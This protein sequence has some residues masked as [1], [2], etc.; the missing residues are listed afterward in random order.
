MSEKPTVFFS[1]A[2][3][4][5]AQLIRLKD[6]F[7]QKTGGAIDV[8]L[9]SDGQ[10][11]PLGVNWVHSLQDALNRA[12]LMFVFISPNS[13]HS[14]WL[15]FE[16][17]FSYAKNIRVVPLGFRGVDLSSLPPPLSLLQGFNITSAAGLDNLI[18]VPNEVFSHNHTQKFSY[19]EFCET[20]GDMAFK[21]QL[22]VGAYGTLIDE[23]KIDTPKA[24]LNLA[25]D[26]ALER[27]VEMLKA[28]GVEHQL[29]G[30]QLA[31]PG[32]IIE[33]RDDGHG[34]EGLVYKIDPSL[35]DVTLP[36]IE[37]LIKDVR[38]DGVTG[39]SLR[40]HFDEIVGC[41]E[42]SHKLSGRLIGPSVHMT[43][44]KSFVRGDLEFQIGRR[45]YF[46]LGHGGG[47]GGIRRGEP[48]LSA[49]MR[50]NAI[51]L[52]QIRHL[53]ED[54]FDRGVFFVAA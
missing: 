1:H 35:V 2:T 43:G 6:L 50:S 46:N 40:F 47:P 7:V 11:I 34:R 19:E 32:A 24:E 3:A 27:M 52:D 21:S 26:I 28:A 18:A 51:P 9:S 14:S 16:S 23:I 37:K 31:I 20:A 30:S 42:D 13:L 49:T 41:L 44:I 15:Y 12:T 53:L 45:N 8:F 33:T 54:V 29:S 36:T 22:T 25:P 48:Y 39:L 5:K 4:D 17:G 10:S 38:N